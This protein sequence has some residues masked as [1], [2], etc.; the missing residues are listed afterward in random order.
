LGSTTVQQVVEGSAWPFSATRMFPAITPEIIETL[1][2]ELGGRFIDE[3]TGDLLISTHTFV[4]RTKHHVILID[5]CA[6]NHKS[7]PG[8]PV[9]EHLNTPYLQ[10]LAA[11]GVTPEE[12]DIVLCT[13][14]HPDHTGW[15]TMLRDGTW[16][17]TYPNAKY[18]MSSLE[19]ADTRAVYERGQTDETVPRYLT[20]AFEDSIL[21]IIEHGQA[22][23]IEQDH[24]VEHE[25]DS[26]VRLEST[27]GH[28][29]AHVAVHIEGGGV[30]ALAT[31]DAFHHLLQLNH[32]LAGPDSDPEQ[33]LATRQRL[34]TT[35]ADTDTIFLPAHIPSPTAGRLVHRRG[36]LEYT[37]LDD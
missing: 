21:P 27:P 9:P 3:Q 33:G 18:L 36:R 32:H 13:H 22:V 23:M 10:R 30:H 37:F 7:R 4:V 11:A 25:L 16:V 31:G 15:N 14:L 1:V 24:V 2:Q 29:R 5:S 19:L 20:L 12:V 28:T 17:P 34:F 8:F 6:G 26:S 35:Y